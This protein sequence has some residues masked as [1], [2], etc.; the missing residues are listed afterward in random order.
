MSRAS[1]NTK[2]RKIKKLTQ[3]DI[4][5]YSN[6]QLD[7]VIERIKEQE[8]KFT[9]ILVTVILI[10]LLLAFYSIFSSVQNTTSQYVLKSNNLTITYKQR[11][12]NMGDII[13]FVNSESLTDSDGM[14]SD[15]YR[16][17]I[18]N[19]SDR[20]VIY[21][22]EIVDDLDMIS[23][24]DCGNKKID[25][26]YIRYSINDGEALS[27]TDDNIIHTAILKANSKIEYSLRFWV[28]GNFQ[29]ASKAHY[30]GKIVVSE[31]TPDKK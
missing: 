16:V 7:H 21:N 19:T 28:D 23:H 12:D 5:K 3:R 13:N 18:T 22:I 20:S 30:H 2:N 10:S 26:K 9:A 6:V 27:L 8:S 24:D 1:S 14:K 31:L 25:R 15:D 29:N 4:K 17:F 11:D